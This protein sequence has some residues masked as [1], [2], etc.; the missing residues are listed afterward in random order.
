MLLL[1]VTPP[2]TGTGLAPVFTTVTGAEGGFCGPFPWAFT[3]ELMQS[4]IAQWEQQARTVR[5]GE[6]ALETTWLCP[7]FDS[8]VSDAVPKRS[9]LICT[10]T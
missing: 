7:L 10:R 8:C 5:P 4:A 6:R 9:I 1:K 3:G 2:D